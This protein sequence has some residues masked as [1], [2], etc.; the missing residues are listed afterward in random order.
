VATDTWSLISDED[1]VEWAVA[2]VFEVHLEKDLEYLHSTLP[3]D[4]MSPS[5]EGVSKVPVKE[6][7]AYDVLFGRGGMTNSHQGTYFMSAFGTPPWSLVGPH[8]T[9][10]E[11][12]VA[13]RLCSSHFVFTVM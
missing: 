11:P 6:P 1:V 5:L 4:H 8:L 3:E 12:R 10:V 2:F 13:V 9:L 7:G